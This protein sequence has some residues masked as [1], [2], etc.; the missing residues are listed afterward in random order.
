[1]SCTSGR[2]VRQH[3]ARDGAIVAVSSTEVKG[4]TVGPILGEFRLPRRAR[5]C[6]VEATRPP[7]TL[8]D[9]GGVSLE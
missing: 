3:N 1:M 4:I 6:G 5:E 9:E 8:V 7:R 2:S